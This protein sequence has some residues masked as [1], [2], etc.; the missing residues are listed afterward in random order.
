MDNSK[1]ILQINNL[2]FPAILNNEQ[3]AIA[4][5]T[6]ATKL[7]WKFLLSE[8]SHYSAKEKPEI[9]SIFLYESARVIHWKNVLG[10]YLTRYYGCI[11]W[12]DCLFGATKS[13]RKIS[14]YRLVGRPTD[15]HIVRFMFSRIV[16]EI[17]QL[18]NTFCRGKGSIFAQS[19]D[20][21]IVNGI[22][23]Q[24]NL[25]KNEIENNMINSGQSYILTSLNNRII[26]AKETLIKF[27]PDLVSSNKSIKRQINSSAFIS[28][29]E[30]GKTISANKKFSTNDSS[31]ILPT[32][33]I[34]K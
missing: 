12:N 15:M 22:I 31:A 23:L 32:I 34:I 29:I 5:A 13:G 17:E 14:R 19:Y 21:G 9:D 8:E 18:S 25:V 11:S 4:N 2:K 7:I 6:T 20:E 33:K 16:T 3:D 28:G 26:E 24:M 10:K 30:E 1:I 27:K